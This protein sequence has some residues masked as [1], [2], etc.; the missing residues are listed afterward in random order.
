MT[1]ETI[2]ENDD[3]DLDE[4]TAGV[5]MAVA[6][7]PQITREGSIT[8]ESHEDHTHPEPIQETA[9]IPETTPLKIQDKKNHQRWEARAQRKTIEN[10]T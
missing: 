3:R 10:P 4:V 1:G 2:T 7:N 8:E 5:T 6:S 9:S